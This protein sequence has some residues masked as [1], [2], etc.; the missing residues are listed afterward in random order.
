LQGYLD[1]I[2]CNSIKIKYTDTDNALTIRKIKGEVTQ[3]EIL[4]E[5]INRFLHYGH[6]SWFE[7]K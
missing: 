7:K 1:S 3:P 4:Q 2:T 5:E 6:G